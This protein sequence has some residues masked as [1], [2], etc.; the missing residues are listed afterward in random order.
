MKRLMLLLA[1]A[2][3]AASL[4]ATAGGGALSFRIMDL[5]ASGNRRNFWVEGLNNNM[6][7]LLIAN[8][9]VVGADRIS[10]TIAFKGNGTSWGS[11]VSFDPT[12]AL[13]TFAAGINDTG[14]VVGYSMNQPALWAPKIIAIPGLPYGSQLRDINNNDLV[15]GRRYIGPN[16]TG[17]RYDLHTGE[18]VDMK[19]GTDSAAMAINNADEFTGFERTVAIPE[20]SIF[21]FTDEQGGTRY[22]LGRGNDISDRGTIVG[23]Y[24]QPSTP[25]MAFYK[26]AGGDIVQIANNGWANGINS[27]DEIVGVANSGAFF[28]SEKRGLIDLRT[29][30]TNLTG[31]GVLQ[32]KAINNRRYIVGTGL[33]GGVQK[34]FMLIP[35]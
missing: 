11:L 6:P 10:R 25:P 23:H 27:R 15:V 2:L 13:N 17:F 21:H 35:N 31:W 28:Y 29:V 32:A 3:L 22:A 24:N 26:K 8:Q 9:G 19:G 16:F 4:P 18:T 34:S 12:T 30:I 33:H 14:K 5:N 7:P 20:S 1:T